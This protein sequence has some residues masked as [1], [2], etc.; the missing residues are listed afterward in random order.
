MLLFEELSSSTRFLRRRL[1]LIKGSQSLSS[2]LASC[3][4]KIESSF[5][6]SS[7]LSESLRIALLGA[8]PEILTGFI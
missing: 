1:C 4:S 2:I 8:R 7:R 3:L 6:R 5:E